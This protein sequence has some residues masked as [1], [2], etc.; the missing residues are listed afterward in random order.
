MSSL[1]RGRVCGH[2]AMFAPASTP[3]S[4]ALRMS[5]QPSDSTLRSPND[6]R[7]YAAISH[8]QAHSDKM[9]AKALTSTATQSDE[10]YSSELATI[11]GEPGLLYQHHEG[12]ASMA[13]SEQV[14]ASA[15]TK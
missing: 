11:E 15:G 5:S 10:S 2:R 3:H 6:S 1:P 8:P 14:I 9:T 4:R 7:V 13:S 12:N